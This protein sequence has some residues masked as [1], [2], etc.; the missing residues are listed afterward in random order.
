MKPL[1]SLTSVLISRIFVCLWISVVSFSLAAQQ[2]GSIAGTV[3]DPSGNQVPKASILIRSK[4]GNFSRQV[5]ADGQGRFSISSVPEGTYEIDVTAT[6]F[7]TGT[8]TGL[9]VTAGQPLNVTFD[10]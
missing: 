3:Q 9:T 10:L 2:G 6:G 1:I 7:A 5:A 8:K 4:A